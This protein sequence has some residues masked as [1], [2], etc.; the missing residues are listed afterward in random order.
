[1][2]LTK[3]VYLYIC[4]LLVVG[5]SSN[6]SPKPKGYVRIDFPEREYQK[7]DIGYPYTFD[8]PVYGIALR[9]SQ[10]NAEPF[11]LNVEFPQYKAKIHLSYKPVKGNL[12]GFIDDSHQLAY[13]HAVKADGIDEIPV[14]R[15][16]EKVYGLIYEIAGNAASSYQFYLTDS[17][18]HFLRGSLYFE[19]IPNKDSLAPVIQFFRQD[20]LHLIE[21]L[22][23]GK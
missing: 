6:Y 19:A 21:T 13:K 18:K 1:M 20:V 16:E 5:C 15:P 23:W 2:N 4:I 22:Q 10:A 12:N 8:Y 17:T 9:D 14:S 3:I 11:W 7:L